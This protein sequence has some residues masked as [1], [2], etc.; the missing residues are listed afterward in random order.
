MHGLRC[1]DV[2]DQLNEPIAVN[3][4]AG[5]DRNVA[6]NL[7]RLRARRRLA[8][9]A[10]LPIVQKIAEAVD[11]VSPA[12]L[13]GSP[14]YRRVGGEEVGRR[15]HVED[16]PGSELDDVL[17]LSRD[18]VD[19]G[20][21]VVPPLLLQ[22]KGLVE[23]DY[24]AIA[25][26]PPQRS[27]GLAG[28][29]RCTARIPEHWWRRSTPGASAAPTCGRPLPRVR[30]AF[31]ARWPSER[32]SRRTPPSARRETA[33]LLRARWLRAR[34]SQARPG[35]RRS[36]VSFSRS[37]AI[38]RRGRQRR[39]TLLPPSTFAGTSWVPLVTACA[40]VAAVLRTSCEPPVSRKSARLFWFLT[41][42]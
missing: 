12:C 10:S 42:V 18:P 2:L 21:G 15:G 26:T 35:A 29:A 16:L 7:E 24:R 19:P 38:S 30:T 5:R 25:A 40:P 14:P 32:P 27:G 6:P 22:E 33:L 34:H 20:G 9:D 28:A 39:A 23:E 1:G 31:L 17:V 37:A 11:E 36:S 3:H 13:Q 41:C 8:A 4:L